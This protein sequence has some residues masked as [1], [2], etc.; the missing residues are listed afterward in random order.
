MKM[1]SEC[2]IKM[3]ETSLISEGI[4]VS[5]KDKKK[6]LELY[7]SKYKPLALKIATE[8]S[9]GFKRTLSNKNW[10]TYH[11]DISLPDL[12]KHPNIYNPNEFPC[13][14]LITFDFLKWSGLTAEEALKG[15][16]E[17]SMEYSPKITKLYLKWSNLIDDTIIK[18]SPKGFDGKKCRTEDDIIESTQYFGEY[19]PIKKLYRNNQFKITLTIRI[20]FNNM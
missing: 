5:R 8:L 17:Y 19:D 4:L 2:Q 16:D 13:C 6:N 9:N 20:L 10:I 18:V 7:H 12:K 3:M 14:Y 1:L 15:Y 11:N